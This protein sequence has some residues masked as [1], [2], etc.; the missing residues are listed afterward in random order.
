M[1]RLALVRIVAP[2]CEVTCR[3]REGVGPGAQRRGSSVL[4]DAARRF[5]RRH[6]FVEVSR[7]EDFVELER[8]G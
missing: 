8:V 1:V 3:Y 5:Y 6:G 4:N 7:D 2:S